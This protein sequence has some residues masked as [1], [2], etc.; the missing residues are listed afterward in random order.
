[1]TS[2]QCR[3]YLS[4]HDF[5]TLMVIQVEIYFV[6]SAT[7]NGIWCIVTVS[8]TTTLKAVAAGVVH[9]KMVIVVCCRGQSAVIYLL[10]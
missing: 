8:I 6:M 9:N 5:I 7:L 10:N 2:F 4:E 1:M 3:T